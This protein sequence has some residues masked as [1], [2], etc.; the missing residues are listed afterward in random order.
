MEGNKKGSRRERESKTDKDEKEKK[1]G[2]RRG[3]NG[4]DS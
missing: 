1:L 4:F 3:W 2:G